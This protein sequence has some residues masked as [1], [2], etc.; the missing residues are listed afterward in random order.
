MTA[1]D[2][3]DI[4]LS[5]AAKQLRRDLPIKLDGPF[6][7]ETVARNLLVDAQHQ[8]AMLRE[9]PSCLKIRYEDLCDDP[10]LIT[11]IRS[12]L[13]FPPAADTGDLHRLSTYA[14]TRHGNAITTKSIGRWHDAEPNLRAQAERMLDLIP[15][16]AEYWGYER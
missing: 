11:S 14:Q 10:H 3:R 2:P 16:Y 15:E 5:L 6:P 1:R 7:P 8:Q 9:L 4:F 13:D 12:F